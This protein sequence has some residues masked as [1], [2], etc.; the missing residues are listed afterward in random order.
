MAR[1]HVMRHFRPSSPSRGYRDGECGDYLMGY[2]DGECGDYSRGYR[3]GECGD[4]LIILRYFIFVFYQVLLLW[5]V[6]TTFS[7]I[8]AIINIHGLIFLKNINARTG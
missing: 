7:K 1:V 5:R 3:E 4:Y 2:R 8:R 6:L